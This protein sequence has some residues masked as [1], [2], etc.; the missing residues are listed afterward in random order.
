MNKTPKKNAPNA[1]NIIEK[2]QEERI[3][4][5]MA[6]AEKVL[7]LL[8]GKEKSVSA[9]KIQCD[10]LAVV[11]NQSLYSLMRKTIVKD[12]DLA[13]KLKLQDGSE[14]DEWN[15]LLA[16][17]ENENL[18]TATEAMQW[19]SSKIDSVLK[20]ETKTRMFDDLGIEIKL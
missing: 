5:I 4:A 18:E 16:V 3:N 12:L 13:G 20:D 11:L 2:A 8:K 17:L 7:P 9:T 14:K 6:T 1:Q 19:L 15:A 10:T